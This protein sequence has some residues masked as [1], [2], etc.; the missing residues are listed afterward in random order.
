MSFQSSVEK[1]RSLLG[2]PGST[3]SQVF[4]NLSQYPLV[5]DDG[6]MQDLQKFVVMMY[7]WSSKAESVD[8]RGCTKPFHQ[9]GKR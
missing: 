8:S 9:P 7:N 3:P 2:K 6:D 1:G 4:R 5:V